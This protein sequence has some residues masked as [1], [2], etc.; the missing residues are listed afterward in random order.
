MVKK[1][2]K[3]FDFETSLEELEALVE[4][5]E[6]GETSL[7]GSLEDFERGIALTRSCQSALQGAEQKVQILLNKDA[8]AVDFEPKTK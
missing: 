7:E 4:R 8:E 1:K 2:T 5:M 6:Q 3:T